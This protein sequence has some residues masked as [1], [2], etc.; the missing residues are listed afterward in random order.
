MQPRPTCPRCGSNALFHSRRQ[1]ADGFLRPLIFSAARC[2]VCGHRHFRVNP[3]AIAALAGFLIALVA[4]VGAGE[5]AWTHHAGL[6]S[7]PLAQAQ[8]VTSGT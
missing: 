7:R 3:L 1:K 8:A 6:Q 4:F 5:M 2:H